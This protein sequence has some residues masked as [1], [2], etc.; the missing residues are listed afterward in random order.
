MPYTTR[1]DDDLRYVIITPGGN[2]ARTT[3]GEAFVT[4][5]ADRAEEA[6]AF[7]NAG[8]PRTGA[9]WLKSTFGLI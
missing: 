3:N 7:L 8:S 5:S 1:T 4:T 2:I 6:A 9:H